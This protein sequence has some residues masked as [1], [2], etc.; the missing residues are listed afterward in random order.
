MNTADLNSLLKN[1]SRLGDQGFVDELLDEVRR[2][3]IPAAEATKRID[4]ALSTF[5]ELWD[6]REESNIAVLGNL[7]ESYARLDGYGK[8]EA[9]Y[10]E[11]GS[12]RST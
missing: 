2:S 3:G 4:M 10:S 6:G 12:D 8:A 1:A 5:R 9:L 7:A 11:Q